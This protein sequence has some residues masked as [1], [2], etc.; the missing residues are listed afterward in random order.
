[1]RKRKQ[2]WTPSEWQLNPD[3]I[4]T[5]KVQYW[6]DCCMLTAQMLKSEAQELVKSGKAFIITEQAIGVLK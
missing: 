1:M 2:K 6:N 4:K 3:N 5:E